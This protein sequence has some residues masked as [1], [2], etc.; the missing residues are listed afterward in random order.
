MTEEVYITRVAKFLPNNPISND[1]MEKYIGQIDGASS[2]AKS[3]VLRNNRIK[4]RYYALDENGQSTHSNAELTAEAIRK[5][6][7]DGRIEL[8]EHDLLS[9]GTTSSDQL[10]PSH[11]SMVHGS[12]NHA[13]LEIMSPGG[14]CCSGMHALKYSYLSVLS[15]LKNKAVC[16]GSE[17]M[18]ARLTADRFEEEAQH[19]QALH[20][21]PMM[22]FE[23]EFLRW[24]LSDGAGAFLVEPKPRDKQALKIEWIE[25]VSY[26]NELETCMYAGAE[27]QE[28]GTLKGW[29]EFKPKDW[30]AKSIFT[31]QQDVKLLGQHIVSYGAKTLKRLIR[32]KDLDMSE[33]AYIL[34]HLSS[35]Y[36]R[37]KIKK[38]MDEWDIDLPEE[39][40]FTNLTRVGNVGSASPFL[41]LEELFNDIGVNK[42]DKILFMVPESARFSYTYALLTVV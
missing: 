1:E 8:D 22:A 40:W 28:N 35:E 26:A 30:L 9:C 13:P 3:I 31:L 37:A 42:G 29:A 24:M 18:S 15:G 19:L 27:K 21:E 34:P 20:D 14:S 39:K 6:F 36:F 11:T 4:T 17:K 2:R 32:E 5:L 23:K 41:M 25:N 16:T 7:A 12:I 38:E 33:L 10:L